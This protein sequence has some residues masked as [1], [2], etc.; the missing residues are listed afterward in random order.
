MKKNFT[1][2]FLI[3]FITTFLLCNHAL[4]SNTKTFVSLSPALTET[5]YA[6]NAQEQLTGVSTACTYPKEAIE[7][8]KIGNNFFINEEKIL[9]LNP[10]YILA[11]DSS[12]FAVNKFK[13]LGITPLCF[14][15]PDI[16][17]IHK[18][19]LEIG[20]LTDKNLEAQEIVKF[21]TEKI[22][23]ANK[24]QKKK[25]L[26]LVQA[27]P[28]ISIGNKSFI[29]D[30]IEKSG[31]ISITR[32]INAFYPTISEEFAIQEKPEIIILSFNFDKNRL[33]KLFPNAKI[34]YLS[35]EEND[36]I[37]RPG[38]RIHKSVEFFANL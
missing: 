14:K 36:I 25:I 3:S 12:E 2:K 30:I 27:T 35:E 28:M 20:K 21:S 33:E 24:N 29:S 38:P 34:I 4:C 23:A 26:Y 10:D 9:S 1:Y 19:I 37:N 17:S 22:K 13:A 6:L 18:N 31:N 16:K 11:L 15:Y 7:K 8:E 32:N 5:M